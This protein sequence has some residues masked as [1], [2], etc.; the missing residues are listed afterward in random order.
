MIESLKQHPGET[1]LLAFMLGG[2]AGLYLSAGIVSLTLMVIQR[3]DEE[4]REQR[5]QA[6]MLKEEADREALDAAPTR[7]MHVADDR[8][9]CPV[10]WEAKHPGHRW[11]F[12]IGIYCR[13]HLPI[14]RRSQ[15]K[16]GLIA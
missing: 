2:S 9:T 7:P 5:K 1:L 11:P 3:L 16:P 13:I 12:Q 14:R 8:I 4:R 6:K 10:C 15:R